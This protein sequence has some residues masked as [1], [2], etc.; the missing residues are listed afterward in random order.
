MTLDT[1][2]AQPKVGQLF[3]RYGIAVLSWVLFL[4]ALQKLVPTYGAIAFLQILLSSIC[5]SWL[6]TAGLRPRMGMPWIVAVEKVLLRWLVGLAI[7]F[8]IY[9]IE[10]AGSFK[11]SLLQVLASAGHVL[12]LSLLLL[13]K[14]YGVEGSQLRD[15]Y[16]PLLSIFVLFG[17]A[18]LDVSSDHLLLASLFCLAGLGLRILGGQKR[19]EKLP[20]GHSQADF[21]GAGGP[22]A[23][24]YVDVIC[25][26]FLL[27][28]SA[29]LI[30]LFARGLCEPIRLGLDAISALATPALDNAKSA[31]VRRALAARINLGFLL[32]GGAL[33]VAVLGLGRLVP[34]LLGQG[35]A[36]LGK[37][38]PWLAAAAAAPAFFGATQLLL[39]FFRGGSFLG[40]SNWIATGLFLM[41]VFVYPVRSAID[42]AIVY[43][44]AVIAQSLISAVALGLKSGVWPGLTALLFRGIKVK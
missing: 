25:L 29:A 7:T 10:V 26:A 23:A 14:S 18:F 41:G 11:P 21:L 1:N 34:I 15:L 44:A 28:P 40:M 20:K 27:P 42:L 5:L 35:F 33:A 31:D 32:I 16:L 36:D 37:T 19:P 6:I 22:I 30:Y 39:P 2:F 9:W 24:R 43:A 12:F 3:K 4:T 13:S 17:A 38:I 8:V